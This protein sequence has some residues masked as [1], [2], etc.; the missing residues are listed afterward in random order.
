MRQSISLALGAACALTLGLTQVAQ[1]QTCFGQAVTTGCKVNGTIGDCIG[2]PGDDK[3][4]GTSGADVIV[5]LGGIDRIKGRKGDDILCGGD[6]ADKITGGN[7]IDLIDAGPGDDRVKG[8]RLDDTVLGDAGNDRLGGGPDEDVLVGGADDDLLSGG[9]GVDTCISG[10]T[11]RSCELDTT[12]TTSTTSTTTSTTTTST[13]TT[14]TTTTSTTTTT[15]T[16]SVCGVPLPPQCGSPGSRCVFVTY[17]EWTGNLGGLAGAD[18]IC[19]A[20]AAHNPG[21]E[22]KRFK[23]WLSTT[24]T[25]PATRLEH[26]SIPYKLLD[27]TTIASDWSNLVDGGL[28]AQLTIDECGSAIAGITW[29][30]TNTDGTPETIDPARTCYEWTYETYSLDED[31]RVG[32]LSQTNIDW[33]FSDTKPCQYTNHLY[34]FEQPEAP[35]TTTTT[36]TTTTSTTTTTLYPCLHQGCVVFATS[37]KYTGNLGGLTGADDKCNALAQAAGL[38]GYYRAW[39]STSTVNAVDRLTPNSGPFVQPP[40]C[41]SPAIIANDIPDLIDGNLD[42]AVAVD[43][44]C[45]IILPTPTFNDTVYTSTL[46]T[47]EVETLVRTCDDWTTADNLGRATIGWASRSD[48]DWTHSSQWSECDDTYRIYCFERRGKKIEARE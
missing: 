2:T 30:G 40:A 42:N 18:Q 21:L 37:E 47:G 20:A 43:E 35:V 25:G 46:Q 8:G 7:G 4:K 39:L 12:T 24:T 27:G 15:I 45:T 23:A 28:D 3:I 1:A 26:A 32:R 14:S 36:S 44:N 9:R 6:G 16:L 33:T 34:C 13:T 29:T 11:L 48:R 22:G 31:G 5:G 38:T 41:A 17:E 19:Q 10:E